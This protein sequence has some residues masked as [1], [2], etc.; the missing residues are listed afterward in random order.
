MSN[1]QQPYPAGGYILA[2]DAGQSSTSCLV[3]L[4]DGTLLASGLGGAAA[5]PNA[6]RT[7][8]MMRLALSTCINEALAGV[9]PRPGTVDAAYLSLTGGTGTALDFLP[10]LIQTGRIKAESDSV[11]ALASGAFGGP[12][13][14]LISGTG[15]V[16]FSQNAQGLQLSCGGWGYLLG[17][18]GSGF[19]IG[20]QA[21]KAAIRAQ[22]GRAPAT[23]LA[24][25]VLQQLGAPEMRE[26]QARVY[27]ELISRPQIARLAPVVMELAQAGDPAAEDIVARAAA[28]LFEL[29]QAACQQAGF[30]R[31]EEKIIVATGGILRPGSPVYRSFVALAA[32]GLPDYRVVPPRFPPVIGAFILGLQL[33]GAT[34]DEKTLARIE[35]T[36]SGLPALHLKA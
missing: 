21:I 29:V 34:I 25:R 32:A 6:E 16:T 18:E 33:A 5:V 19:W 30:T 13:L 14:A 3:G 20:L 2:V 15:C 7:A 22:E 4:R 26:V 23:P 8:P 9:S 17:D 36:S 24:Q 31:G 28:E 35:E 10:T 12:G 11:A 27:N 1:P